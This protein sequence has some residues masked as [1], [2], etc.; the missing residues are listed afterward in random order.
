M[1]ERYF[2]AETLDDA[3]RLAYEAILEGGEDIRPSKGGAKEL[4]GVLLRIKNPRSRLSRTE[5]RG[6]PFSCLG[7]LCWYLGRKNRLD[8]IAYY[9]PHYEDY[10]DGE[11]IYGAY[12]PRML[13][14]DG[15][16]QFS[17]VIELLKRKNDSR[18]AVIQ[19]F[20][21]TD[22]LEPHKDIP[23]TCTLQFLLRRGRVD[24]FTQM[25]S[26]DA[27]LGMP[28]DIF[29]F[30]MLQEVV[31]RSVAAEVGV[32]MHAVGSLHI[33]DENLDDVQQFLDEGFQAT[34][35]MPQMPAG[36]PWA[37]IGLVMKAEASLR[38]TGTLDASSVSELD[39][40]W[41]DLVRL[42]E[43][44]CMYKKGKPEAIA[45]LTS[46]MHTQVYMPFIEQIADKSRRRK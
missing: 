34:T 32:Y 3:M 22:I 41:Q 6:K 27:Y 5:S 15:L 33:Y 17:N 10:A 16:D 46:Q 38:K 8:H 25:R 40:Y 14:W 36:D 1:A 21:R 24:M 4:R 11:T 35:Q 26:N 9:L 7:E 45:E 29:A 23:C 42:L 18:Q 28:H 2:S 30:T 13:D 31:A 43:I 19:L 20:D 44:F 39:P 37:S 12:G